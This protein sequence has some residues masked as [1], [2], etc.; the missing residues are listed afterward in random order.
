MTEDTITVTKNELLQLFRQFI[1]TELTID[2]DV[3]NYDKSVKVTASLELEGKEISSKT[4][5]V[6]FQDFY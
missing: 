2:L 6:Y 3:Y 1:Q 5:N 4:E